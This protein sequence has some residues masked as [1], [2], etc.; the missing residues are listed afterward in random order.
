MYYQA[1]KTNGVL[2]ASFKYGDGEKV[3]NSRSFS[4]FTKKPAVTLLED[5][6]FNVLKCFITYDV[7]I[8]RIDERWVNIFGIK[9]L[10]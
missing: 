1:L 2:Y 5:A 7:R 8:D 6:D 10:G 9:I 4:D 3:H